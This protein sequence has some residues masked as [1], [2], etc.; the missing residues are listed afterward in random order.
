MQDDPLLDP[1]ALDPDKFDVRLENKRVR[2]LEARIP[3]GQGH[4]MHWHPEHLIV[5]L[6]SYKVQDTF[7][8]GSTKTMERGAGELLWGDE[9][10][11]ATQNIGETAVHAL[12]VEFKT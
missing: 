5:T 10:T 11:H 3:P 7:T 8:D 4:G 9:L 6:S 1:V 12:I 2:V